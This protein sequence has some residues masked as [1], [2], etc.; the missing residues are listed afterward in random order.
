MNNIGGIKDSLE[1]ER[2]DVE[3]RIQKIMEEKD[4]N[5]DQHKTVQLALGKQVLT[6]NPGNRL[7]EWLIVIH[8]VQV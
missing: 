5:T 6:P 4:K 8:V 3:R 7:Q 2:S 1:A